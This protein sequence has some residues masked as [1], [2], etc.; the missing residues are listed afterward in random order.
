MRRRKFTTGL[1]GLCGAPLLGACARSPA[2]AGEPKDPSGPERVLAQ[3]RSDYNHVVVTQQGSLR[4]MYFVED[5]DEGRWLLQSTYDLDRPEALDH[6]VFRTMV[7]ALLVQPKVE[8]MCMIGVGG[9]QLSNY[10]FQRIPGLEIDAVDIC[11]EVVR[12][13]KAY[14]GVPEDPNYRLHVDDGRAFIEAAPAHSW[15]LLV[16]DAYRG[17]SIPR[18]LRTQEFFTAC[19]QR[20][21]PGGVLIANMHRSKPRYP[22][23]RAAIA[24]VFAHDYRFSSADWVQTSIVASDADEALSPAQLRANAEKLQPRFDFDLK[25][26]AGRCIIDEGG[27]DEQAVLHDDFEAEE[28]DAAASRHNQ[29]CAPRCAGDPSN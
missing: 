19:A 7:S 1:L 9:G 4:R 16:V 13:A 21:R 18:H 12:L 24:S 17:H 10:L 27:W 28:L 23:D 25:A 22:V 6:E 5:S 26:L 20:L 15:D 2:S 8:R 14:F 11:P 29:S 3:G